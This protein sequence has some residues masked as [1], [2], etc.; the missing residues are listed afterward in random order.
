[1]LDFMSDLLDKFSDLLLSVF[2]TSPF[3]DFINKMDNI[4]FLGYLN[5]FVP[6]GSILK[7]FVAYLVAVGLFYVYMVL[8]RW[9]KLIGD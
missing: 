1:M 8:A 4:P 6:V 2:P 5:W 3:S 9:V 7:I